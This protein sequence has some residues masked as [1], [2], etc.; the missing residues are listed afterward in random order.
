MIGRVLKYRYL[1]RCMG[2][3][4]FARRILYRFKLKLGWFK[5]RFPCIPWEDKPLSSYLVNQ[6]LA[7]PARYLEFRR[8]S[9]LSFLFDPSSREV[10]R[11]RL[12]RFDELAEKGSFGNCITEAD[13]ILEGKFRYFSRHEVVSGFSPDWFLNPFQDSA[14]YRLEDQKKHWSEI[15]DFSSGDIKA[16]WELSRFR[17]A[18]TLVRA[19]W[20]TGDEKYP[21]CFWRLVEDWRS[22]NPPQ[23]GPNWKCGQ[24]IAFRIMAWTFGLYGFLGAEA[25]TPGRVAEL[26][27]MIAVSAERIEINISYALSQRNNH[28]ISEALGLWTVGLLFPEFSS[29]QRWKEQGRKI[30]EDCAKDLIYPDGT[31]SQHS[32]NYH[33]LMLHDYLWVLS[34]ADKNGE[35]FS[36]VFMD[37]VRHAPR[38]LAEVIDNTTGRVPNLGANDGALILPLT[39][40]DYLDYRPVLQAVRVLLDGEREFS[41]GPWDEALFWLGLPEPGFIKPNEKILKRSDYFENGGL[42][43]LRGKRS[44]AVIYCV[45]R[46]RH[47]PSHSD[48]LHMDLWSRGINILRD[49]GT[50]SYNDLSGLELDS[51]ASHNTVEFDGHDQMPRLSRFLFG[52]WT[53]VQTLEPLAEKDG[54]FQW[55]GGYSDWLGGNHKRRVELDTT[56]DIWT[57]IDRVSGYKKKAVLRWRLAPELNWHLDGNRAIGDWAEIVISTEDNLAGVRLIDGWESLYYL[58]KTTIPVLAVEM[59]PPCVRVKTVIRFR[60]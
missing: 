39:N 19:Y 3:G 9:S 35:S 36:E 32:S 12:V 6:D 41:T 52:S 17:S 58:E 45:P 29:A 49:S 40:C 13:N 30:L 26:S 59:R 1:L 46:Y 2:M 44:R 4:W 33:R 27:R 5:H 25:T 48:Q 22:H 43:V 20:R 14:E 55:E 16:V 8:E 57:I 37:R 24:E 54:L 15:S 10:S 53:E 11:N 7:D 47:R 31:F 60:M 56:T 34:L 21:E 18:F 28:P 50:Y 38:F 51:T 23:S 42:L